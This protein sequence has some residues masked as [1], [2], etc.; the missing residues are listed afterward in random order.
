MT[1][2]VTHSNL[3]AGSSKTVSSLTVDPVVDEV[4]DGTD[5][6]RGMTITNNV[7]G[8]DV[9]GLNSVA[10]HVIGTGDNATSV[11]ID[12]SGSGGIALSVGGSSILDG[13]L[14]VAGSTNFGASAPVTMQSTL[15][16]DGSS[17]L[18]SVDVTND[19]TVGGTLGVT[20]ATTLTGL[21]AGSSTLDSVDVTNDATVGGTFGVTGATTL[22]GLTAGAST[23]ASVNVT[24]ISEL[25][26][27]VTLSSTLT[28]SAAYAD[29]AVVLSDVELTGAG[30]AGTGTESVV[31]R[32][33]NNVAGTDT[34]NNLDAIALD[35]ASSAANS[36]ALRSTGLAQ[37]VGDVIVT[38]TLTVDGVAVTGGGGSGGDGSFDS[39][40]VSGASNLAGLNAGASTLTSVGVT[41]NAT[42]GG[43]LGVTGASTLNSVGVTNNA[44]VGGT[45]G[46][47]GATTLTSVSVSGLSEF[48]GGVQSYRTFSGLASES[49]GDF[50]ALGTQVATPTFSSRA[51]TVQ[52]GIAGT[53]AYGIEAVALEVMSSGNNSTA[54]YVS[55]TG[56]NSHALHVLGGTYMNGNVTATGDLAVEGSLSWAA[57]S[58]VQY[59]R[60]AIGD[61]TVLEIG[62]L[63]GTA[64]GASELVSALSI[65]NTIAG[66]VAGANVAAL[67]VDT[68][69]NYSVALHVSSNPGGTEQ[70]SLWVD[71]ASVFNGEVAFEGDVTAVGGL[72]VEGGLTLSS[73]A[74][75][76]YEVPDDTSVSYLD[77]SSSKVGDAAAATGQVV[78]V[79]NT[80]SSVNGI[81]TQPLSNVAALSGSVSGAYASGVVGSASEA[82]SVGVY[83]SNTGGGFAVYANG[84]VHITGNLTVDGTA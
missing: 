72:T 3:F 82:S 66:S 52:S 25:D 64:V 70:V 49:V 56:S 55:S 26:G 23:L 75:G 83:A 35:V 54:L 29:V 79:L 19:A 14:N 9:S 73:L 30:P 24:G 84:N 21:T 11:L 40:T 15:T 27:A 77:F 53:T 74:G 7:D 37:F 41:N 18:D 10:L 43:T 45:L 71:G 42:V 58:S 67:R 47:T 80:S 6:L 39:L 31:L 48:P 51:L 20:G 8:T 57:P 46:V 59:T 12:S 1:G 2:V 81:D 16:V 69:G 4:A 78:R 22:T 44:T 38:G 63:A 76:L 36:T 34:V 13:S 28:Q 60:D 50:S 32:V 33:T 17:T 62:T 5:T 68:A 61:L 65:T